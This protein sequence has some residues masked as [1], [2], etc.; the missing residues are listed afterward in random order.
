AGPSGPM[1]VS[2]GVAAARLMSPIQASYPDIAREARVQGSV[3]VAATISTTGR[4]KNAHAVSGPAL[5]TGAA[6]TAVQRARYRPFVLNGV[7]VEAETTITLV[8]KLAS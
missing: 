6:L 7:P 3:V 1:R 5:L 8:F 4:I 2:S